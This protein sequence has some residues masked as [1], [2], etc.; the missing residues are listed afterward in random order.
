MRLIIICK[1]FILLSI[2]FGISVSLSGIDIYW[3]GGSG[4]WSDLS[5]W[6]T[7]SG[8]TIRPSAIPGAGD[9]VI[10]DSKSFTG[11]NQVVNLDL[12]NLFVQSLDLSNITQNIVLS[13]ISTSVL[14]IF[15]D[16]KLSNRV[17]FEF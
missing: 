10:F 5:N 15:G 16:L 2:F 17:K 14:N 7:I 4:K 6:S 9:N 11:P 1:K 3:I 13:G 8:G 12:Q